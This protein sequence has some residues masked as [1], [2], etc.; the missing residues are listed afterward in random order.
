MLHVQPRD[1]S[2]AENDGHRGGMGKIAVR[3]SW[4]REC[5]RIRT[6]ADPLPG[7]RSVCQA[8]ADVRVDRARGR[9]VEPDGAFRA[10]GRFVALGAI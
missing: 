9:A 2:A 6:V 5:A 3:I 10:G 7:E 1:P 8:V 4:R